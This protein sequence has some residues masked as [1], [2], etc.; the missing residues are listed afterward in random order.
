VAPTLVRRPDSGG[1]RNLGCIARKHR[2]QV[3]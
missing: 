2:G 3:L 1:F